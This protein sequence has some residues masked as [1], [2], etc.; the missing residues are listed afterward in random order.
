MRAPDPYDIGAGN[1]ARIRERRAADG[2][3]L[4]MPRRRRTRGQWI[5]AVAEALAA[6]QGG[7]C[8]IRRG[9]GP[10]KPCKACG[11]HPL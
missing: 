4:P 6:A 7:T 5:I 1:L 11:G 10:Q 2:T 9:C 8:H 3:L